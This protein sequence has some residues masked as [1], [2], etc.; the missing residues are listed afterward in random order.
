MVGFTKGPW[1]AAK[2][3]GLNGGTEDVVKAGDLFVATTHAIGFLGQDADPEAEAEANARLIAAA[4]DLY[5]A[6]SALLKIAERNGS[7]PVLD[8]ARAA[9]VKAIGPA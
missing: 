8:S 3:A 6:L 1:M 4:P 2:D 9:L 5:E 7:G